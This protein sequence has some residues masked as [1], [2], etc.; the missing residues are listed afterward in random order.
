MNIF[1]DAI[2]DRTDHLRSAPFSSYLKVSI[3]G[4]S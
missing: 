1:N 4:I 2:V 3:L